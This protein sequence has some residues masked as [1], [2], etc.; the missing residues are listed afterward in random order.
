MAAQKSQVTYDDVL[1]TLPYLKPEEQ[2]NLLEVLSSA[3]K[4]ALPP[5]KTGTHSLLELEGL[6]AESW[7]KV[8]IGEYVRRE[9][10]SW[11]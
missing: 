11:D 8:D 1:A 3:L 6:G 7:E 10:D 5:R 4:K 2:R 9:R